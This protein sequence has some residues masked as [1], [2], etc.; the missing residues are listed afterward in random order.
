MSGGE[1]A[2]RNEHGAVH[3]SGIIEKDADDFLEVSEL[4]GTKGRAG[5][6]GGS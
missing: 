6:R 4:W 2:K 1:R 5:V 3:G